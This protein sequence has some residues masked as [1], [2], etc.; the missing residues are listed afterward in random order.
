MEWLSSDERLAG[1]EAQVMEDQAMDKLM[2][3]SR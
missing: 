2:E 3:A 1:I